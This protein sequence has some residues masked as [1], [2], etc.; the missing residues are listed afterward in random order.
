MQTDYRKATAPDTSRVRGGFILM[1]QNQKILT[2]PAKFTSV[3]DKRPAGGSATRAPYRHT[4]FCRGIGNAVLSSQTAAHRTAGHSQC[5]AGAAADTRTRAGW[6]KKFAED[7]V[8]K[9]GP[10]RRFRRL[11]L[12]D[13]H[14]KY[15]HPSVWGRVSGAD[16]AF[17]Q[18]VQRVGLRHAGNRIFVPAVGQ[19]DPCRAAVPRQGRHT[20]RAQTLLPWNPA[21]RTFRPGSPAA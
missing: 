9:P 19:L 20:R 8:R 10:A 12:S 18:V 7:V 14:E 17:R 16:N 6:R 21:D 4:A 2:D 1:S 15:N 3:F 11:V 13:R 5:P